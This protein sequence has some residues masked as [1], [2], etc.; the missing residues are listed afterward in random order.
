MVGIYSV[1]VL[2]LLALSSIRFLGLKDETFLEGV[3]SFLQVK[4]WDAVGQWE[5]LD[6]SF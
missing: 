3:L 6:Y 5:E 2:K 1:V 4:T